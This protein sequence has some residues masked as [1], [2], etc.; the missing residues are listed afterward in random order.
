[1]MK[2][3]FFLVSVAIVILSGCGPGSTQNPQYKICQGDSCFY[4][5]TF[6]VRLK[7]S[8]KDSIVKYAFVV[9]NGTYEVTGA[10][11]KKRTASDPPEEDMTI[12]DRFNPASV[13]KTVTAVGLLQLMSKKNIGLEDKIFKFLPSFWNIPSSSKVISFRMLMKHEAGILNDSI[14]LDLKAV[15]KSIEDGVR[16]NDTGIMNYR[17]L[18]YSVCR[19]LIAYLA[20]YTDANVT[21]SGKAICDTFVNYLQRN[22]FTPIGISGVTFKPAGND[23]AL[24]YTYPPGT[25]NGTDFGDWSLI[26]GSAGIQLSVHELSGFPYTFKAGYGSSTG[27]HENPDVR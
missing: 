3:A 4:L 19:V 5:D 10:S 16:M 9:R 11:G 25:T 13:T 24:F 26:G 8:L 7:E 12:Y 27:Q 22:V 18:N 1:M 20:G 6:A 21:D 15:R 14:G 23:R 2:K 17:N